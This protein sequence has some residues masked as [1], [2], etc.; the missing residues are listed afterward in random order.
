MII[1]A[2]VTITDSLIERTDGRIG[3]L[4]HPCYY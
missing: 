4:N 2:N 1:S 3:L